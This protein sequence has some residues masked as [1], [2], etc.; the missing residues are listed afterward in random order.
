MATPSTSSYKT[1]VLKPGECIILPEGATI[2]S[3]ILDGAASVTSTCG[4]LPTP[5][6]YKC[7]YFFIIL[8]ADDNAGHSMDMDTKYVSIKVG[9]NTYLINEPILYG[10]A[11]S[12]TPTSVATLNVHITDLVLFEFKAVTENEVT[13]RTHIHLYFKVPE[14]LF[15]TVELKIDNRGVGSYMYLKPLVET[16]DNYPTPA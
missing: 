11:N 16:C 10:D 3:V 5:S 4:E 7:G 14:I 9:G 2:S 13:S 15:D 12:P 6:T 8:D 1:A